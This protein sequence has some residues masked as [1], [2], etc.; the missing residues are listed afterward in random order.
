MLRPM[1]QWA[2]SDGVAD[3]DGGGSA[4]DGDVAGAGGGTAHG[5]AGCDGDIAGVVS[6]GPDWH[7]GSA[8][9]SV[10]LPFDG[11]PKTMFNTRAD[12]ANRLDVR[13]S[14]RVKEIAVEIGATKLC[15]TPGRVGCVSCALTPGQAASWRPSRR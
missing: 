2:G 7:A 5:G 6:G 1:G 8:R 3:G 14:V 10:N 11:P 15:R 13:S 12:G 4:G 9:V